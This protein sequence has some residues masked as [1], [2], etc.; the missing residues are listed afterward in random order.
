MF[1]R[2]AIDELNQTNSAESAFNP[3]NGLR[4]WAPPSPICAGQY[5]QSRARVMNLKPAPGLNQ[6]GQYYANEVLKNGNPNSIKELTL[7][8]VLQ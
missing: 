6:S 2:A 1:G 3:T 5:W 8:G 7:G 4:G